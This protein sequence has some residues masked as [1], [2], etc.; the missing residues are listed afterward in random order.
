MGGKKGDLVDLNCGMEVGAKRIGLSISQTGVGGG[1]GLG[2]L[3]SLV[4]SSSA[5]GNAL[6]MK[7]T[8]LAQGDEEAYGNWN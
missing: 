6:L 8:R 7:G 5:G 3:V 2:S 4:S 1:G